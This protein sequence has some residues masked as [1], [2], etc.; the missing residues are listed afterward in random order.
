MQRIVSHSNRNTRMEEGMENEKMQARVNGISARIVEFIEAVKADDIYNAMKDSEYSRDYAVQRIKELFN[1]A[2]N[3]EKEYYIEQLEEE[4][5][6]NTEVLE[7]IQA[8]CTK[9]EEKRKIAEER[10]EAILVDNEKYKQR[11]ERLEEINNRSLSEVEKLREK[12]KE[13]EM[14]QREA[15]LSV[16]QKNKYEQELELSKSQVYHYRKELESVKIEK[17][18]IQLKESEYERDYVDLISHIKSLKSDKECLQN[19]LEQLSH[20][21]FEV[22][23]RNRSLMNESDSLSSKCKQLQIMLDDESNSNKLALQKLVEGFREKSKKLK[24]KIITQK[25]RLEDLSGDY[26]KLQNSASAKQTSLEQKLYS[27]SLHTKELELQLNKQEI[28]FNIRIEGLKK[29]YES[30]MN[31]KISEM[32]KEVDAQVQNCQVY[33]KDLKNMMESKITTLE[34]KNKESERS[35][36]ELMRQLSSALE[37]LEQLRTGYSEQ[38]TFSQ[39]SELEIARARNDLQDLQRELRIKEQTC[40]QLNSLLSEEQDRTIAEHRLR[41]TLE[42]NIGEY[43]ENIWK[44]KDG[45]ENLKEQNR[46]SAENYENTLGEY[47]NNLRSESSKLG[48]TL[49]KVR[50]LED[51]AKSLERKLE[52]IQKGGLRS[53]LNSQ[54]RQMKSSRIVYFQVTDLRQKL[55]DLRGVFLTISGSVQEF[56]RAVLENFSLKLIEKVAENRKIRS[57]LT[58]VKRENLSLASSISICSREFDDLSKELTEKQ[59]TLK[60]YCKSFRDQIKEK[61]NEK[62]RVKYLQLENRL[63]QLENEKI[64]IQSE[65]RQIIEALKEEIMRSKNQKSNNGATD[66]GF[67]KAQE[68]KQHHQEI[69]LMER[70]ISELESFLDAERSQKLQLASLKNREIEDLKSKLQQS[71]H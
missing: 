30:L 65:S 61:Y 23:E 69:L 21:N 45:L 6:R 4:I 32:Q 52:R 7:E 47:K 28:E 68:N 12:E 1:E 70:R 29:H 44:L 22:K 66:T 42:K 11:V 62:Y 27:D 16:T 8:M 9:S 46:T 24:S 33:E 49:D 36:E 57:H 64:A 55:S 63:Q 18:H 43:E 54:K 31:V 15:E 51:Y 67:R 26:E 50:T 20:I 56:N 41:C 39:N 35:N 10:L 34:E 71:T 3:T 19:E 48:Y 2:M 53:S 40:N 13:K 25:K 14:F 60:D 59:K 37:G 17:E 38:L 5:S 58:T